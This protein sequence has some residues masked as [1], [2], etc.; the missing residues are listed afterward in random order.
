MVIQVCET[1][2]KSPIF[3][4]KTLIFCEKNSYVSHEKCSFWPKIGPIKTEIGPKV[5]IYPV[6]GL[7]WG[8]YGVMGAK[9]PPFFGF[10]H[11]PRKI[12]MPTNYRHTDKHLRLVM[13]LIALCCH[14]RSDGWTDVLITHI[15]CSMLYHYNASYCVTQQYMMILINNFSCRILSG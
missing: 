2:G 8:P 13:P 7:N 9:L 5:P 12:L 1:A 3:W 15:Y 11:P 4:A 14:E 6:K 10:G